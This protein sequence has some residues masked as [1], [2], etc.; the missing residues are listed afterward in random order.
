MKLRGSRKLLGTLT[1]QYV[2]Y[3]VGVTAFALGVG[4]SA[5]GRG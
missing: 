1:D 3:M 5:L 2:G 4:A